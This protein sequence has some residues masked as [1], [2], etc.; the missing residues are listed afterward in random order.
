MQSLNQ[1][2]RQ[3]S[4]R[5]LTSDNAFNPV[6][7][8]LN[9]TALAGVEHDID[10]ADEVFRVTRAALSSPL[11]LDTARVIALAKAGRTATAEELLRRDVLSVCP[12]HEHGQLVLASLIMMREGA[13][14]RE[15]LERLRAVSDDEEIRRA[16]IESLEAVDA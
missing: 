14:W 16:A 2:A 12:E 7:Y 15:I 1:Y 8:G 3:G 9:M 6:V 13:G 10:R 4:A 5:P 11:S